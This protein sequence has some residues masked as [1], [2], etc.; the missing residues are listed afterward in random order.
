MESI[1]QGF[2][3]EFLIRHAWRSSPPPYDTP[4]EEV[5][6][7]MYR[8]H[9]LQLAEEL[10]ELCF[11]RP[12]DGVAGGPSEIDSRRRLLTTL[13]GSALENEYQFATTADRL[14]RDE[15]AQEQT[16]KATLLVG[17][18]SLCES[19][20]FIEGA[21]M[22]LE[23]CTCAMCLDEVEVEAAATASST[24]LRCGHQFHQDCI[25]K[26]VFTGAATCPLCRASF[27]P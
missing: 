17:L 13:L 12:I 18:R 11:V 9:A 5:L 16:R 26:W 6:A 8:A 23:P 3:D 10:G 22:P 7:D 19:Q 20:R 25:S 4:P 14:C 27:E 1:A 24:R 2:E 15:V 21:N